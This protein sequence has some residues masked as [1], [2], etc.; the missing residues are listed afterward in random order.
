MGYTRREA[1]LI[2]YLICA[3]LGVIALYIT[4]AS[5]PEG[6]IIGGIVA[7]V[8]AASLWRLEQVDFPGK[9]VHG[10]FIRRKVH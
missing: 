3:G 1:V 5:V 7:L 9:A 8:G 10:D 4:Q 2:C 6:Y